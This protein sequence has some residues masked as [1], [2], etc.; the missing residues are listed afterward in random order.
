[1]LLCFILAAAVH[2]NHTQNHMFLQLCC[3]V[4]VTLRPVGAVLTAYYVKRLALD[5]Q[6]ICG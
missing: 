3:S 1:M 5:T 4:A 2:G 6:A